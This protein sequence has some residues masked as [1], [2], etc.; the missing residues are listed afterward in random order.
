VEAPLVEDAPTNATHIH[1]Y[2]GGAYSQSSYSHVTFELATSVNGN[3][4][5]RITGIAKDMT[6]L[7]K[8]SVSRVEWSLPD[9]SDWAQDLDPAVTWSWIV[10]GNRNVII[11]DDDIGKKHHGGCNAG[12]L[13]ALL[14]LALISPVLSLKRTGKK[15]R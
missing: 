10:T 6:E 14:A 1:V 15:R 3:R 4:V 2:L 12:I 8:L 11:D 5:L 9:G 13:P 7:Q